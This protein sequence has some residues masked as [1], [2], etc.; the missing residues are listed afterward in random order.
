MPKNPANEKTAFHLQVRISKNPTDPEYAVFFKRHFKSV[1][2][3]YEVGTKNETP[4]IH[5]LAEIGGVRSVTLRGMLKKIFHFNGNGDFSVGNIA[6][7]T[8]DFENFSRYICKG[9]SAECDPCVTFRT[10][11]WYDERVRTLH[12]EYYETKKINNIFV[13]IV[14]LPET[15]RNEND[16]GSQIAPDE[17]V[18]KKVRCKTWTEKWIDQLDGDYP[19]QPWDWKNIEH[20]LIVQRHLLKNLGN[21]KKC[22]NEY[23]LKEWVYCAFNSLGAD[24][25]EDDIINRL[26]KLMALH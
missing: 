20:K 5:I 24:H 14:T 2:C 6:P 9:E 16:I 4:H 15:N 10:D 3:A 7:T 13:P 17:P 12:N 18:K 23:K 1:I 21:T 19:N 25:F 8:G 11:D 26:N 22:F